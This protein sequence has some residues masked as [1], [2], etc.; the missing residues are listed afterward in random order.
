VAV[1]V[2]VIIVAMITTVKTRTCF[3]VGAAAAVDPN[4]A[5]VIAPSL[6]EDAG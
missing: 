5:V 1:A 4:A 6:A 2:I 3:E